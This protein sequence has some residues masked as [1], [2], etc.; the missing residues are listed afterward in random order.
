MTKVTDLATVLV[1][2]IGDTSAA[3]VCGG[4]SRHVFI[5]VVPNWRLD[6]AKSPAAML[7]E[8]TARTPHTL[9]VVSGCRTYV[10]TPGRVLNLLF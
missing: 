2:P 5:I 8:K 4:V 7:K 10:R 9:R 6:N 1:I 3:V